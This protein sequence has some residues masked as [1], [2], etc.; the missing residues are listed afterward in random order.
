LIDCLIDLSI[1]TGFEPLGFR[2]T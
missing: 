1:Y 2:C